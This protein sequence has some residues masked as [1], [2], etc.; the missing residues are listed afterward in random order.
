MDLDLVGGVEVVDHVGP[1]LLIAM[2]ENVVLWVHSPLNLVHL[3][4]SVWSVLGHHDSPLEFSVDEI[5]VVSL[6]PV[7]D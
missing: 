7:L 5:V 3:V 4:G 2:V 1:C 6:K